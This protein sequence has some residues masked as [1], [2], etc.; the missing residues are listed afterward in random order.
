VPGG[1]GDRDRVQLWVC[2]KLGLELGARF[3]AVDVLSDLSPHV[4]P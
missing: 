2:V 4:G 1:R 3:T